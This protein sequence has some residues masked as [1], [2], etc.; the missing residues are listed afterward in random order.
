MGT[1]IYALPILNDVM[2]TVF[3]NLDFMTPSGIVNEYI[4]Y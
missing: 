2:K 1:I 3:G 4:Q